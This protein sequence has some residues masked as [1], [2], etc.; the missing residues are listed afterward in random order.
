VALELLMAVSV[1]I[2]Q[3]GLQ[4]SVHE[5]SD[6]YRQK[7]IPNANNLSK[8]AEAGEYWAYRTGRQPFFNYCVKQKNS[9]EKNVAQLLRYFDPYVWQATLSV[10]CEKDKNMKD[11]TDEQMPLLKSFAE[12]MTNA[13]YSVRL[14]NPAGTDDIGGGCGQLHYFQEWRK[15]R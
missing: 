12:L 7:I 11:T 9:K 14:F 13:G 5:S 6:K 3:V 10:I 1:R 4:F 2:N 15:S 8:L